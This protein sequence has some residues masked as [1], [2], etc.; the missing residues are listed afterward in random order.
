MKLKHIFAILLMFIGL[1]SCDKALEDVDFNV[2]LSESN[3]YAA[4]SDVVFKIS[5]TPNW[6]TFYSGKTGA[7]YPAGGVAIK[8][9]SNSLTTYSFKYADPGTYVVTFLAGNT[10]YEGEK[11]V[12]KEL[13][14]TIN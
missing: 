7:V 4:G 12:V 3:T 2:A 11:T 8:N 10:N 13:T 14:I 1:S 5:G 9:I 6:V